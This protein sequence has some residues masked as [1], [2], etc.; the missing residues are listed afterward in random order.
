MR[1]TSFFRGLAVA[2]MI[3][4]AA[5]V[6]NAKVLVPFGRLASQPWEGKY[7][8]ASIESG[9]VPADEWVNLDF[10][11]SEWGS[12]T[13]PISDGSLSYRNTT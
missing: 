1:Q 9:L 12:V 8:Y 11:D 3:V 2:M 5:V 10:D 4:T 6:A 13:G 7:F